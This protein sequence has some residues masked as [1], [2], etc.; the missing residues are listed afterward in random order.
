MHAKN[1]TNNL[2]TDRSTISKGPI[3]NK[4]NQNI[5]V[6]DDYQYKKVIP[7][8]E[9]ADILF[10]SQL[11]D[12]TESLKQQIQEL[13][14]QIKIKELSYDQI[15]SAF[16]QSQNKV[17]ELLEA[18]ENSEKERKILQKEI[19]NHI[20]NIEYKQFDIKQQQEIY[21]L[22]QNENTQ[23]K[24]NTVQL[25]DTIF[26]LQSENKQLKDQLDCLL[27]SSQ[28]C[29]RKGSS[30]VS[31]DYLL[32]DQDQLQQEQAVSVNASETCDRNCN[33]S[34]RIKFFQGELKKCQAQLKEKDQLI[35]KLTEQN[36]IIQKAQS[37]LSKCS[38]QQNILESPI[39]QQ[40][41]KE[42]I[43]I[44]QQKNNV[45]RQLE[46]HK[47]DKK[48]K[49]INQGED[50]QMP[51]KMSSSA[52]SVLMN[53]SKKEVEQMYRKMNQ[54]ALFTASLFSTMLDYKNLHQ[55]T[56]SFG[57]KYLNQQQ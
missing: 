17:E 52:R 37:R 18:L 43:Q 15:A 49:E 20:E 14:R 30:R 2:M 3:V 7:K 45:F 12:P 9:Q 11:Y 57:N 22:F 53:K 35:A 40:E 28:S 24:S 56:G 33:C 5:P 47:S 13:K 26:R 42:L 46:G 16:Y 39:I 19:E 29:E 1:I 21:G 10:H 34:K 31:F 32:N 36:L 54:S 55:N 27:T 51:L 38:K 41:K 44:N 48:F 6:Y 50:S 23:L 8:F 4:A 25:K